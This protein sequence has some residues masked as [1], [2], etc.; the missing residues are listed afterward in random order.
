MFSEG[1]CVTIKVPAPSAS[2]GA[3]V[4]LLKPLKQAGAD[5]TAETSS[6]AAKALRY[7]SEEKREG[8]RTG[9]GR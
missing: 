9:Q 8:V 3:V 4:A 1:R 2:A 7:H 5:G 6:E